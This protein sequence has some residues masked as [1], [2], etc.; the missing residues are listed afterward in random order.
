[1]DTDFTQVE[2]PMKHPER[3]VFFVVFPDGILGLICT[4]EWGTFRMLRR[5]IE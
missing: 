5:N 2:A 4:C 1:M 3:G